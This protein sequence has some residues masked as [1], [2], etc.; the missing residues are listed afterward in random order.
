MGNKEKGERET[1]NV[2]RISATLDL[3]NGSNALCRCHVNKAYPIH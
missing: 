2:L 3:S 1:E